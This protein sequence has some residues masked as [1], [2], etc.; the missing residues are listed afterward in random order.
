MGLKDRT[1]DEFL[2]AVAA[3]TPTPG[4]GSVSAL[5]GACAV[6]LARMVAGL[7]R[8]KKGFEA[9]DA[10]LVRIEEKARRLQA[11]LEDL[12]TE[13]A[14]AYE[15]VIAA[16][17]MPR[18]TAAQKAARVDAMQS[19]Y[20]GATEVPLRIVEHSFEALQLAEAAL[21]AGNRS[22]GRDLAGGSG[23]SRGEPQLPRQPRVD[24]GRVVSDDR[25]GT[26]RRLPPTCGFR[27]THRDGHRRRPALT[28]TCQQRPLVRRRPRARRDG[29]RRRRWG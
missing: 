9:R 1:L 22:R 12:I 4:G 29:M 11:E 26:P 13:D 28:L 25:G 18:D 7:A 6:A 5:A 14:S 23:D 3:P 21:E 8:G 19:A 20:R 24:P 2:A 15:V 10:D 17:R 27:R 16:M